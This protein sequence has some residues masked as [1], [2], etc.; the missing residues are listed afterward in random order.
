[1]NNVNTIATPFCTG[2]SAVSSAERGWGDFVQGKGFHLAT[3]I[4]LW[5]APMEA[6]PVGVGSWTKAPGYAGG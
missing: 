3:S 1:M 6:P 4:R 2:A 5:E